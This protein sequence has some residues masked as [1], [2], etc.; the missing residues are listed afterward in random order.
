MSRVNSINLKLPLDPQLWQSGF[1]APTQLVDA[2]YLQV[3]LPV[4]K[5]RGMA[6]RTSASWSDCLHVRALERLRDCLPARLQASINTILSASFLPRYS[7]R[8]ENI[9]LRKH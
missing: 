7:E 2:V 4:C 9:A 1:C 8:H 6:A 3:C 5:R